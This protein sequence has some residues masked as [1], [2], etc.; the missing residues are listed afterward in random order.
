M[1]STAG[2]AAGCFE[3]LELGQVLL[4]AED[5]IIARSRLSRSRDASIE[6][7]ARGHLEVHSGQAPAHVRRSTRVHGKHTQST[8]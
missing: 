1:A 2:R 4:E 8:G 3:L 5:T 6:L 7:M